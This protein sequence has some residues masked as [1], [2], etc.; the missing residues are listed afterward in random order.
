M[1]HALSMLVQSSSGSSCLCILIHLFHQKWQTSY[2]IFEGEKCEFTTC[3]LVLSKNG[4]TSLLQHLWS[5]DSPPTPKVPTTKNNWDSLSQPKFD[6]YFQ[7]P[8]N[9]DHQVPKAPAHV[10]ADSTTQMVHLHQSLMIKMHPREVLLR[11]LMKTNPKLFLM[12]LMMTL[13]ISKLHT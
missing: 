2:A 9:V 4:H 8:K 10:P 3:C 12:V 1:F 13:M 5:Y 7:L 11:L 6:E